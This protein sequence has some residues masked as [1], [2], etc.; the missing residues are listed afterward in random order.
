MTSVLGKSYPSVVDGYLMEKNS[1]HFL[2]VLLVRSTDAG[3]I[4]EA[5]KSF[6]E[7]KQLY[8]RKLI[9]LGYDGSVHLLGR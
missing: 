6:L 1:K 2:T 5:L 3:T 9:F 4:A 7:P 8:L